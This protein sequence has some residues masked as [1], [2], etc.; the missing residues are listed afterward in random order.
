MV[1]I[2]DATVGA[3]ALPTMKPRRHSD[4]RFIATH[5]RLGCLKRL[6]RGGEFG[7]V[8]LAGTISSGEVY[9]A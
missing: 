5:H 9:G 6:V 8:Y 4:S 1:R 3:I 2:G 7:N